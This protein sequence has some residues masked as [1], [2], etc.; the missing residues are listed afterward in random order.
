MTS[1]LTPGPSAEASSTGQIAL[2]ERHLGQA[3]AIVDRLFADADGAMS[4]ST[5]YPLGEAGRAIHHAL[6]ALS[7]CRTD[8]FPS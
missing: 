2:A 8:P 3:L 7:E 6:L 4:A 5:A 1:I